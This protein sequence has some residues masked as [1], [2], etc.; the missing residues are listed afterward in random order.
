MDLNCKTYLHVVTY[1]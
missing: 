1:T